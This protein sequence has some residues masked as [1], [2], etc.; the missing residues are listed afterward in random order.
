ML[1]YFRLFLFKQKLNLSQLM[2]LL[3]NSVHFHSIEDLL[4]L[5]AASNFQRANGAPGHGSTGGVG[6]WRQEASDLPLLSVDSGIPW[7]VLSP[8]WCMTI[9]HVIH[10]CILLSSPARH[11][12]TG[13]QS[14]TSESL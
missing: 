14:A 8:V 10:C 12:L 4:F 1:E 6:T 3:V 7:G 13:S 2:D 11:A 5:R 9:N